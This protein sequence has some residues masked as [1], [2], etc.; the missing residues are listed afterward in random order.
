M[1]DSC[2]FNTIED[3]IEYQIWWNKKSVVFAK[4]I[5]V[6]TIEEELQ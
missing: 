5:K 4:L 6:T 3:A 1:V 2:K